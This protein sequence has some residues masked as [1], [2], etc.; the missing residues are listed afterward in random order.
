MM[1]IGRA[2]MAAVLFAQAGMAGAGFI[3]L[4]IGYARSTS[5]PY[6]DRRTQPAIESPGVILSAGLVGGLAGFAL[7]WRRATPERSPQEY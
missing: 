4:W 3:L 1:Q 2:V 6:W 5:S 7:G